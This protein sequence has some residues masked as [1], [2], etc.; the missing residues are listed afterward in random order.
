MV[1]VALEF[2]LLRR[3]RLRGKELV[4][5]DRLSVSAI[6]SAMPVRRPKVSSRT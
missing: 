6:H 2:Q 1:V 4:T 3:V 5:A